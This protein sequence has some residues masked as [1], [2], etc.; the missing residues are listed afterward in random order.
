MGRDSLTPR[1]ETT[2]EQ[3]NVASFE[4]SK[5]PTVPSDTNVFNL[6]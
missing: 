2:D 6:I 3:I 4:N 1:W 5:L